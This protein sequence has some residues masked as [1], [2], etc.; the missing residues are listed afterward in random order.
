MNEYIEEL[1]I[2]AR[3]LSE[4]EID[5]LHNQ[6]LFFHQMQLY[7]M[8]VSVG[9]SVIPRTIDSSKVLCSCETS[10]LMRQGCQCGGK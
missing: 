9:L 4:K 8:M 3:H 5:A 10:I 7:D 2:W 1:S 6:P